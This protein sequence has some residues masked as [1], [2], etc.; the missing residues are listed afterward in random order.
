MPDWPLLDS[1]PTTVNGWL[2]MRI[3]SPT[4]STSAPKSCSWTTEPS[5]A[6][7]DAVTTSTGAKKAPKVAGHNRI[8][9]RST[10]VPCTCVPQFM[11]PATIWPRVLTPGA[12][13]SFELGY[14]SVGRRRRQTALAPFYVATVSFDHGTEK[15]ATAHVLAVPASKGSPVRLPAARRPAAMKR[16]AA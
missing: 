4:G 12:A 14:L 5:T 6:T 11:L 1:T 10:S 7:L 15:E 8:S 16:P 13:E 2:L 9:G 3:I